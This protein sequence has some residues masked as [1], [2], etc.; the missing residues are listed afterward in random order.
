MLGHGTRCHGQR[1]L[2]S[3]VFQAKMDL[4]AMSKADF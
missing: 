4:L 1:T 3:L 2:N